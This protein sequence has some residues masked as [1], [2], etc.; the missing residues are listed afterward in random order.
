MPTVGDLNR[1]GEGLLSRQ[2]VTAA[3]GPRDDADLRLG[4][5]PELNGLQ[6]ITASSRIFGF[7]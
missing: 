3:T 2:S 7:V 4:G 5:E 6:E 1:I